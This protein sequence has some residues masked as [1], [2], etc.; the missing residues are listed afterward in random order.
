MLVCCILILENL[1][2][3]VH[4]AEILNNNKI[5][6][7]TMVTLNISISFIAYHYITVEHQL[8]HPHWY[9]KLIILPPE[10]ILVNSNG[11]QYKGIFGAMVIILSLGSF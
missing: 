1:F 9:G 2:V 7:M 8:T 10:S 4:S 5:I 3:S 6:L 11:E